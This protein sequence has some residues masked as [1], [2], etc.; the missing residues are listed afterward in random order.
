MHG[1]R[2]EEC[3]REPHRAGQAMLSAASRGDMLKH[4]TR[5]IA[6]TGELRQPHTVHPGEWWRA[7]KH[8]EPEHAAPE[9]Q[10]GGPSGPGGIGETDDDKTLAEIGPRGGSQ[11]AAGINPRHPRPTVQQL[12]DHWPEQCRFAHRQWTGEFGEPSP[13]DT[14]PQRTIQRRD[15]GRP[16]CTR[17]PPTR[18]NGID[19]LSKLVWR[20]RERGGGGKRHLGWGGQRTGGCCR[21]TDTEEKPKLQ[22]QKNPPVHQAGVD[23]L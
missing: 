19:L 16:R 5:G 20:G 6:F 23:V 12:R 15:P 3:D 10:I 4:D 9:Q 8:H 14:A 22:G 1:R 2:C 21:H 7:I 18:H 17:F 13:R 11:R